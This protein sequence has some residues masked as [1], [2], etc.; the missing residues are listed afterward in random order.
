MS[1]QVFEYVIFYDPADEENEKP[2]IIERGETICSDERTALI[3]IS[4]QIPE[5]Y[6]DKLDDVRITIR[7]F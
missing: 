4:R 3:R 6:I 2:E 1:K 7:P 5:K